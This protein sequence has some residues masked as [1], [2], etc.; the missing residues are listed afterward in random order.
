[1]SHLQIQYNDYLFTFALSFSSI[2][3]LE[4]HKNGDIDCFIQENVVRKMN[5]SENEK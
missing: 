4:L 1:M 5:R 3:I 2:S